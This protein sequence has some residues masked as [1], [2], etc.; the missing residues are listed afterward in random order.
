MAQASGACPG[1][2]WLWVLL[3]C[4]TALIPGVEGLTAWTEPQHPGLLPVGSGEWRRELALSGGGTSAAWHPSHLQGESPWSL[5]STVCHW[6]GNPVHG[7]GNV[8]M[9]QGLGLIPPHPNCNHLLLLQLADAFV[10]SFF[11]LLQPPGALP[12]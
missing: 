3:A 6:A 11:E 5:P 9:L 10:S 2:F 7:V 4:L 1:V 12:S 8:L